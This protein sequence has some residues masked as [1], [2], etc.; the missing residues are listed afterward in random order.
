MHRRLTAA[1]L[2]AAGCA[3]AAQAAPERYELDPAHSQVVFSFDHLGFST[4]WNV[5]P[6]FEGEILFDEEDPA[7][8]SVSV[9]VPTT[10]LFTGWEARH[11]HF[12]SEDFLD[13]EAHP[14]ISFVSTGIEVTGD[15]TG[16]I[17]GDLTVNG[18]TRS[19]V[20]DAK[21]NKKGQHPQ[22][23]K[24]WIGF[25]ATTTVTR[26]DFDAGM[27]A[28]FVG[29]EMEVRITIEAGLAE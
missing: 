19:V 8:S 29:D 7:S 4:I 20:L 12:M 15:D 25:D 21:L 13:A 10:A 16:L 26:S 6:G 23:D 9:S 11:E 1:A 24:P 3:T 22:A 28:P 18:N 17:T 2:I 5:L 27:F 14:T